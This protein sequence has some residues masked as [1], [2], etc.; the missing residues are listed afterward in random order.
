MPP[1][2]SSLQTIDPWCDSFKSSSEATARDA[3]FEI[4]TGIS[5]HYRRASTAANLRDIPPK[6]V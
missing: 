5:L 2:Y 3:C 6:S 1:F 4:S